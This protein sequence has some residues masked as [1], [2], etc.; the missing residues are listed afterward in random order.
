[1]LSGTVRKSSSTTALKCW[2]SLSVYVCNSEPYP[3]CQL[4]C[5][6]TVCVWVCINR[7]ASLCVFVCTFMFMRVLFRMLYV[8]TVM[9]TGSQSTAV[10]VLRHRPETH[11]GDLSNSNRSALFV[12]YVSPPGKRENKC[13]CR[14]VRQREGAF[15]ATQQTVTAVI[16]TAPRR[17][18]DRSGR[19]T[20]CLVWWVFI[21]I[22]VKNPY[23]QKF[24]KC[25]PL[26][27]RYWHN[28]HWL[29]QDPQCRT[30]FNCLGIW[31]FAYNSDS[32]RINHRCL[33]LCLV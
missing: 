18:I 15:I 23:Q 26:S 12:Y 33:S 8:T 30:I 17:M 28:S 16:G 31:L 25:C 20:N 19:R 3:I 22:Y 14:W 7:Y 11:S 21:D 32:C 29:I 2:T 6:F 13:L 9:A 24:L 1:M 4:T 5:L 27:L 10:V